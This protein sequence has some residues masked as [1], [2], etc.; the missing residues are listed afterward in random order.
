MRS[1]QDLATLRHGVVAGAAGGF[2]EI[3]WVT[4][5]A[6]LTGGDPAVLA[7]G[8]T[9]AAGVNALLPASPVALGIAVHMTLAATLGVALA[10]AWRTLC[11][12][13]AGAAPY[14][15][16]LAALAGVWAINFFVI[17]PI[18]SPAF[19]HLVPYAVSLTSKVL[20]GLAAAA[21]LQWQM[22]SV[23]MLAPDRARRA[24]L[25]RNDN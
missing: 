20:F 2:A 17:L 6:G 10:F 21:A 11:E 3:A 9:S 19:V 22:A 18:V 4:F 15:F 12:R 7:R 5:Y 8:V 13:R 25:H 16:M 1:I 23:R 24:R 14:P